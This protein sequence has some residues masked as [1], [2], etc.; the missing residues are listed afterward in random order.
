MSMSSV[1]SSLAAAYCTFPVKHS[2]FPQFI[3][4]DFCNEISL[5]PS[6][7]PFLAFLSLIHISQDDTSPNHP[8]I[9]PFSSLLPHT[10]VRNDSFS[11]LVYRPSF[12]SPSFPRIPLPAASET[13]Y[14][15]AR[16]VGA[17][18]SGFNVLF[19][20][21]VG[22]GCNFSREQACGDAFCSLRACIDSWSPI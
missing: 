11:S 20:C 9:Q 22:G 5:W 21:A 16:S 15:S 6:V 19:W 8:V 4:T 17:R 1:S 14:L 2:I 7:F 3:M 13:I 18:L 12:H 10:P